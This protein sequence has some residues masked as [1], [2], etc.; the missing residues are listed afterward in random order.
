VLGVAGARHYTELIVWKLADEIRVRTY[1]LTQ[2]GALAR[3]FKLRSQTED[4]AGSVSRNIVEGFGCDSHVEFARFLEISR[5]S[6]NEV[7]DCLRDAQLKSHVTPQQV[8]PIR[9]LARR[10]FPAIGGLRRYLKST[11]APRTARNRTRS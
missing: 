9:A 10:L 8:A 5:R 2:A 11:P 1:R 6:L 7:V 4:A 3:D